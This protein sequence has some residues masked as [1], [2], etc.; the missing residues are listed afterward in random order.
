MIRIFYNTKVSAAILCKYY[1]LSLLY[2]NW[3][4]VQILR[5]VLYHLISLLL[6]IS[7]C[8]YVFGYEMNEALRI[9]KFVT[10]YNIIISTVHYLEYKIQAINI[11]YV[12]QMP[13]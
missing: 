12:N 2:G 3:K 9:D 7:Y 4:G 1:D 10:W 5:E 13:Y 6:L 8:T 11:K